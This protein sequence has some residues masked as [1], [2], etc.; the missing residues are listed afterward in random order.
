[1]TRLECKSILD[2]AISKGMHSCIIFFYSPIH[3]QIEERH[4][5]A[6]KYFEVDKLASEWN[7]EYRNLDLTFTIYV[8]GVQKYDHYWIADYFSWQGDSNEYNI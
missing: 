3:E 5:Y 8:D 7:K 2:K 1:M 6:D 4:I